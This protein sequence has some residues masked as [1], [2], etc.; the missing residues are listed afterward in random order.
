MISL[1]AIYRQA[2][3]IFF[4]GNDGHDASLAL[5]MIY[6]FANNDKKLKRNPTYFRAI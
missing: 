4:E 2:F 6:G 3:D 5:A 1:I